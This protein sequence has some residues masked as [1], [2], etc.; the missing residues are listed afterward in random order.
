MENGQKLT[1]VNEE[2]GFVSPFTIKFYWYELTCFK[3]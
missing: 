1:I 2:F 3:A